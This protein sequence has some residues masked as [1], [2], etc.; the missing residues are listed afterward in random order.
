MS[1]ARAYDN[2]RTEA[3][4]DSIREAAQERD[5]DRYLQDWID[6]EFVNTECYTGPVLRAIAGEG[7]D[8][9]ADALDAKQSGDSEKLA[10]MLFRLLENIEREIRKDAQE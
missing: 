9:L 10:Q 6:G 4:D 5:Q 3:P 7:V 2:W 8:T 1:T